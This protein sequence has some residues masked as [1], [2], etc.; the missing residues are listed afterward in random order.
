MVYTGTAAYKIVITTSADV[1]IVSLDNIN[2][3]PDTSTFLTTGSTS[4]LSIPVIAKTANYTAVAAD[5]GKTINANT[6]G[7]AF[8]ITLTAAATLGDGWSIEVRNAGTTYANFLNLTAVE[9]I[10]FEGSS[11][12]LRSLQIGEAMTIRCDGSAF[13]IIAHTPPLMAA[14][15]PGVIS[16]ASRVSSAPSATAAAR[17]IVTSAFSTYSVGDI[18]EGNNS[19]FNK[20]TPPTD[21]GWLAYVQDEDTYYSFQNS[22]WV[23]MRAT[24]AQAIAGTDNAASMTALSTRATVPA[25]NYSEYAASADLTV[26]LPYDDT[27]PAI[28]EGTE[29]LTATIT[30]KAVT[31][32]IRIRF[33]GNAGAGGTYAIVA[34]LFQDATSAAL[35]VSAVETGLGATTS[36]RIELAYEHCPATTSLVTYRIRVGPGSAGTVRMNGEYN[37]RKFGGASLSTLVVEELVA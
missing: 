32:R 30:P 21:C 17:Y 10:A 18:I 2:G 5:N 4:S 27:V 34:A 19:T 14:R 6:T 37:A 22:A 25:R 13:K 11:F 7:G 15:G 12:T 20:Y 1:T 8:T 23:C 35:Q 36:Q 26:V 31:S 33:A 3:A 28:T 9:A 24:S 29:I 16:V